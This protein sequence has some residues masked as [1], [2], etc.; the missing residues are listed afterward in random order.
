[1]NRLLSQNKSQFFNSQN[2]SVRV[3]LC[4]KVIGISSLSNFQSMHGMRIQMSDA[5]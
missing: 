4:I 3:N 2:V 5:T 1:M